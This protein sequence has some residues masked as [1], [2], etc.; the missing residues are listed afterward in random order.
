MMRR[1]GISLILFQMT[2][3]LARVSPLSLRFP[4]E[5]RL[6]APAM[7]SSSSWSCSRCTFLNPPSQ[8]VSCQICLSPSATAD[9]GAGA[10]CSS[11]FFDEASPG[12]WACRACTFLNPR[13]HAFCEVCG[14]GAM[15]SSRLLVDDL[16]LEELSAADPSIGSVFLPLQRCGSKRPLPASA[17]A[18]DGLPV[19]KIARREAEERIVPSGNVESSS[20]N[21]VLKILSYNVW[22]R[23][24]IEVYKRMEALGG[25]I[26]Q[27]SPDVI[28]FQEVTPNIYEIFQTSK[29]WKAYRCSVSLEEAAERSYFC[30][31]MSKLP[32]EAF[33]RKPFSNSVMGRELC[34]ANIE[35]NSGKSLVIATSHLES[36]CPAPPK[37]DQM[38]SLE[39]VAQAKESLTILNNSPNAIF[40]GDMNWDDKLDGDF[41]LLDGWIDAWK[42]KEPEENGWT[43][44]TKSNPMLSGNRNLQKRLD[45]FVCKLNDFG[46]E[47]IVMIGTQ[48][49]PGISYYKE[50][51]VR[52]QLQKLELPVLPSDHYG[53]LLTICSV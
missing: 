11:S 25:L 19:E 38:F 22:F 28:C 20:N 49:I 2:T 31:Q 45:R 34:L 41:P 4:I 6:A 48:A 12:R 50:K 47:S 32:V 36:P 3:E 21:K 10:S 53:L 46:I 35:L 33:N 42:L 27:H 30:M 26:Q 14:G 1:A 8:K 52:K 43:Y 44:D 17:S 39:R 9:A 29:W 5:D 23:E 7:S 13:G 16:D 37:W 51:K 18:A 15:P 24:D 40:A